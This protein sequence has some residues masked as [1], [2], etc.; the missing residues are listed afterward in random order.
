MPANNVD[1]ILPDKDSRFEETDSS[2]ERSIAEVKALAE[3]KN[4]N[5]D[6]E[7][8]SSIARI[9]TVSFVCL[10]ALIL[11]GVPVYN[12][13]I[14][15]EFQIDISDLLGTFGSLYGTALG[16]VLGYFFKDKK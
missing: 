9:I 5:R 11:I 10:T 6:S 12:A 15:R 8:R 1:V 13:T 2:I 14:G 16:F 3:V 4:E 7:S